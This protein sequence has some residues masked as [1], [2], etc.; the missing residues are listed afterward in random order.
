M[1]QAQGFETRQIHAGA[2]PDPTTGARRTHLPDHQL[3]FP[4]H[5]ARRRP[6]RPGRAGQHLHPH[7]EPHPAGAR[8]TGRLSRRW[9]RRPGRGQRPGGRDA[10]HTHPGPVRRPSRLVALAVRGDVQPLPLHA[11]QARYRRVLRRRPRRPRPVGGGREAQH[12]AFY[13]ESIGNPGRRARP[14]R[15]R[16]SG[17]HPPCPSSSTTRWPAPTSCALWS[18]GPTSS[19]TRP[20]SSS[21]AMAP[22]SGASSSTVATS[23]S[24][25]A[26][27]TPP[28]PNRTRA[29]TASSTGKRSG[30][31]PTWPR[32][33]C[34]PCATSGRPSPLSTL[35][36]W[37]RAS[38]P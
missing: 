34:S 9:R 18:T 35:S 7:H 16:R 10:G 27:A 24:G 3:R 29:T 20:P 5:R 31:A 17:A 2:A 26:G 8:R 12:R 28:S 13:G 1:S 22:P 14:G 30:R 19:C 11:A 23:T 37:Y 36:C 38:R 4:R 15:R 21:A 25:R 32:R 6:V 33:A